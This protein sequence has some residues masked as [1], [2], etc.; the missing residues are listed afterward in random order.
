M[1][2]RAM[3]FSFLLMSVLFSPPIDPCLQNCIKDSPLQTIPEHSVCFLC[4]SLLLYPLHSCVPPYICMCQRFQCSLDWWCSSP[5]RLLRTYLSHNTLLPAIVDVMSL[6]VCPQVVSSSS[7]LQARLKCKPLVMVAFSAGL[8]ARLFPLTPAYPRQYIHR[9]FW[10]WMSNIDTYISIYV[11][12][13][14][15]HLQKRLR[16]YCLGYAGV[17]GNNRADRPAEK[18]AITSGL[19]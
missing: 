1:F 3:G 18:A 5:G 7:T 4:Q 6:A 15:I 10:R 16:T 12:M 17:K 13:F 2:S 19:R 8:S 9:R 11:S 14:D